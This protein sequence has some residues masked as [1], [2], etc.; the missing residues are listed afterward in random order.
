VPLPVADAPALTTIQLSA[1]TAV[2]LQVDVV[3]TVTLP[4]PPLAAID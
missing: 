4:L 2:Q 1:L 3:V